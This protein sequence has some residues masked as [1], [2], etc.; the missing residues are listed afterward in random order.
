MNIIQNIKGEIEHLKKTVK[1][2]GRVVRDDCDQVISQLENGKNVYDHTS[3][4]Y[5]QYVR[6]LAKLINLQRLLKE[7]Y[8]GKNDDDTS[9]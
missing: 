6:N 1:A 7:N 9:D 3:T 8:E 2:Y 4:A 5:E